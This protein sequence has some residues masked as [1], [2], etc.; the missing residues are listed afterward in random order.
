[1][2]SVV[3]DKPC[4]RLFTAAEIETARAREKQS[5]LRLRCV[6]AFKNAEPPASVAPVCRKL[7]IFKPMRTARP[8]REFYVITTCVPGVGTIA[9]TAIAATDKR[10][11]QRHRFARCA[12]TL[13][14]GRQ[15]ASPT[16]VP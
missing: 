14:T 8:L 16:S 6:M 10:R 11:M 13:E 7:H 15:N 9:G 4:R 2:A 5:S 12:V 1:M 3:L